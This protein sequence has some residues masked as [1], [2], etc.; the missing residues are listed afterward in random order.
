MI[1]KKSS[2]RPAWV[3]PASRV[4]E[5]GAFARSRYFY[6]SLLGFVFRCEKNL[7]LGTSE[8]DHVSGYCGALVLR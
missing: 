6:S 8:F 4:R 5:R 7:N 3:V 1:D 2:V